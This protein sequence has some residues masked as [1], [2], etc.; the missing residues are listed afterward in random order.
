MATSNSLYQRAID[1]LKQNDRGTYSL[2]THGLYPVQFNWDS[3]FAA[4]G[5]R[6]INQHRA[7]QEVMQLAS[8]QWPDGMIPH[9]MFRGDHDGYFPGPDIWNTGQFIE[10]S[11]ITQP[12]VLASV[13]RQLDEA[14]PYRDVNGMYDMLRRLVRWHDWFMK[15]RLDPQSLGIQI[16]HP[17]ESGR[18]NLTDWDQGMARVEVADLPPYTRRDLDHVDSSQ[19]PT[20][21]QYDRY[22][23]IVKFGRDRHWPQDYLG[24]NS[25]F[26]MV[27][28]GMTAFLLRSNRDLLALL[29]KYQ[30]EDT[31]S[32]E[33]IQQHT[34]TLELGWLNLWNPKV[35][36]Y[37]AYDPVLQHPVDSVSAA[38]FLSCYASMHNDLHHGHL[39]DQFDRIANKVKFMVPSFDPE[40]ADFDAKRYWRGPVWHV[41]NNRI[42]LGFSE[43]GEHERAERI[44]KDSEDLIAQSSFY[45][46]FNPITGDGLG[47]KDFTWTASVYLD[48]VMQEADHG[49][50]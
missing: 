40:H 23:T 48:W 49:Q 5:Y 27:D 21:E 6:F 34:N 41:I 26:R 20:K 47:G 8:S 25:P 33:L 32:I 7:W 17:W 9:I 24:Q 31:A 2:P 38:S 36:A 14:G 37:T 3:A 18:D 29:N 22:L 45:E 46:Y 16:I 13:V 1:V 43:V 28:P 15:A 50:D 4:L 11:G 19:R 12:P 39:M 35:Q 44:R 30:P 42:G 10:T